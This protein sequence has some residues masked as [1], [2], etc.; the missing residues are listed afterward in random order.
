MQDSTDSKQRT[1][2]KHPKD[3]SPSNRGRLLK[4]R[5]LMYQIHMKPKAVLLFGFGFRLSYLES[6]LKS[7]I[8]SFTKVD[9]S[10]LKQKSV[11]PYKGKTTG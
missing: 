10:V 11:F 2:L 6:L 5:A 8:D 3:L 1:F 4:M 9:Q 7:F